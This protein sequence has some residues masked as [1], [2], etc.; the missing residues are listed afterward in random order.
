MAW[1]R[2]YL[3]TLAVAIDDAAAAVLF[4]RDDVTIS[5]LCGLYRRSRAGDARAAAVLAAMGLKGWQRTFLRLVGDGLERILPG[6]CARAIAADIL[7]GQAMVALLE[8]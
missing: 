3:H 5:S 7:R 6:H 8:D 1:T 4:N 2:T